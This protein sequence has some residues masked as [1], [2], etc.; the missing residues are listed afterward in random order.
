MNLIMNQH[1][2]SIPAHPTLYIYIAKYFC[3]KS[4]F[5]CD[6]LPRLISNFIYHIK[7]KSWPWAEMN[8]IW[9]YQWCSWTF[10][11]LFWEGWG[12]KL[13]L[14]CTASSSI[15]VCSLQ[16]SLKSIQ[17]PKIIERWEA[18]KKIHKNN[19]STLIRRVAA[20]STIHTG[21]TI[22]VLS[23]PTDNILVLRPKQTLPPNKPDQ[24]LFKV[25][26]AHC[27]LPWCSTHCWI[28]PSRD[29]PRFFTLAGLVLYLTS[30][31]GNGLWR[32]SVLVDVSGRTSSRNSSA[33]SPSSSILSRFA[34]HLRPCIWFEYAR[35]VT[36]PTIC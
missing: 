17:F 26:H 34:Y 31:L 16:F 10:F 29:R 21:Q 23:K 11:F 20:G 12:E 3:L 24:S 1:G 27:N 6:K 15:C 7:M 8:T 4:I 22:T 35:V 36:F 28:F 33:T 25:L 32:S 18:S 2:I 30:N 19:T 13:W 5:I 14:I 9:S